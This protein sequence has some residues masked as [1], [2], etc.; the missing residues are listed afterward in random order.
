MI[1]FGHQTGNPNAHH[2]ALTHFERGWL[3]AFVTPWFPARTELALLHAVPALRPQ[4]ERLARRHFEPL[5]GAP[6]VQDRLGEWRR[7]LRRLRGVGDEGLS[8]EVND[9]LMRTMTVQCRRASVTAVHCYEDASL[10][11]FEEAKR[12][13]K[14]CIYDMPIG[15]YPAWERT[16]VELARRYVDWFP[17][18]GLPSNRFVRPE[19]K[20]KEMALADLVLVPSTFVRRS[21]EQFVEKRVAL[22]P[23]GVD[24][25]FWQPAQRQ[26]VGGPLRFIY[27]GQSSLRKGIPVLFEAWR[28]AELKDATLELV[29]SWEFT[30]ARR[31][32][33]PSGVAFTGPISADALREKYQSSDVFVFPS[34]FEG[35]GLVISEAMACG[36]PVIASDATAGPDLLDSSTGRVIPAG[37]KDAL[38]GELRWFAAHRERLPE[39][40]LAARR[41]AET[42]TWKNYRRAVSDAVAPSSDAS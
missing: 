26:K 16:Q 15:Y 5:A 42:C 30:D 40:K 9:W 13:G 22:A 28:D 17:P 25:E 35:F 1:L 7:M 6:K 32:E 24:L 31:R 2:A 10:C 38:V 41:K 29:G 23:Y 8:Y 18:G 20:R 21:I 19:Q 37:D 11:E 14:A 27:A 3:D 39:M 12:L 4:V 34:F 33:L 36:L